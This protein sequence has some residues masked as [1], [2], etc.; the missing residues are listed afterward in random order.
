MSS[1][2]QSLA[3][4]S[5]AELTRYYGLIPF[6]AT[7]SRQVQLHQK[8]TPTKFTPDRWLRSQVHRV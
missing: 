4:P 3:L 5:Y 8:E 2:F 6:L 7:A 1:I